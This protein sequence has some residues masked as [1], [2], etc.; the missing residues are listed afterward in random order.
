MNWAV[1]DCTHPVTIIL[2]VWCRLKEVDKTL[3]EY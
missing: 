3:M 1:E 2:K